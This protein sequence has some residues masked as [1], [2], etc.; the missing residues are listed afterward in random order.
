MDLRYKA[1]QRFGRH[2]D[3]SVDLE[4]GK[5]THYTLLIYLSGGS[6]PKAKNDVGSP[7]DSSSEPLVGGET[8]FYGSRNSVVA[9][10]VGY[11]VVIP[12]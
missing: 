7:E 11:L 5:R 12:C 1:G 2:I 10:V 8:V 3:E 4:D 9:E 6:K